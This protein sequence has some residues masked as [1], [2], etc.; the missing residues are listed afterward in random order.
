MNIEDE[1]GVAWGVK[2]LVVLVSPQSALDLQ[3]ENVI[4]IN[5][6]IAMNFNLLLLTM[7]RPEATVVLMVPKCCI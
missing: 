6:G 1:M 3:V 5:H 7:C 4:I 2:R